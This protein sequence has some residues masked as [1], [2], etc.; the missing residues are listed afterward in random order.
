VNW[1]DLLVV[2]LA[3]AGAVSG[4]RSGLATALFTF[5]GIL[6]GAVAGLKLAPLLLGR[7][8]D[9]MLRVGCG[10]L[11]L[12]VLVICGQSLGMWI[13]GQLRGGIVWLRLTSLDN[14][15][16]AVLQAFAVLVA[17]WLVALP[18]TSAAGL[19]GLA[20]AI[21]RSRVL[22]AV[23]SFMPATAQALPDD[24][25]RTLAASGFP[26]PVEPF[27]SSPDAAT[28]PPDQSLATSAVVGQ[29]QPSVVKIHG[30]AVS[31]GE[32]LEGSGFVIAPHRVVTNAHVVAGTDQVWIDEGGT[33]LDAT[34]VLY[35]PERDVAVLSVPGLDA[36]PLAFDSA[37]ANAGDSVIAVGYPLDGPYTA[38]P[39]RVRQ[40]VQLEGPDI[41]DSHVV[42]REV[43]TIRGQ[44]R[45]GNS[46]GPLIDPTGRVEGVVFAVAEDN[47]DTGFV[48]TANEV[49]PDVTQA[50]ALSEPVSTGE[51]VND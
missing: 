23:N 44:I 47:P 35:D 9:D 33:R 20:S 27:S 38:S 48:L 34:V 7:M 10:I 45:S 11:I 6:L 19:P 51:C 41:D 24:L 40:R 15:L 3:L 8:Q 30:T 2:L 1:V 16:G 21:N 39:G 46:G 29:D 25:R 37:P 22:R 42:S 28:A 50:A 12:A 32:D 17:A 43:Y 13:G 4:A 31:C 49:A 26:L 36:S 14:V 5:L 18:L